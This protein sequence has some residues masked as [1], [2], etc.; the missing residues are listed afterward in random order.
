MAVSSHVAS[1]I[2]MSCT[3]PEKENCQKLNFSL[4]L[5]QPR[6]FK[7][8]D[9]LQFRTEVDNIPP[10]TIKDVNELWQTWLDFF[11]AIL[12]KYSPTV[13][14]KIRG[15]T[16]PYVTSEIRKMIRQRISS[17]LALVIPLVIVV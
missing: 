10:D 16:T 7:N 9:H 13:I 5:L 6:N 15:K 8:F 1:V 3:W 14:L 17:K 12:N 11:R 4:K 2:M